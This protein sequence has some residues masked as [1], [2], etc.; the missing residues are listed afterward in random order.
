[1]SHIQYQRLNI[2]NEDESSED[3]DIDYPDEE[4][5]IPTCFLCGSSF[6][7]DIYQCERCYRSCCR[8]CINRECDECYMNVMSIHNNCLDCYAEVQERYIFINSCCQNIK[9]LEYQSIE[10]YNKLQ[11]YLPIDICNII[12]LY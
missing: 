3:V 11:Q 12:I 10:I 9:C 6:S 8:R 2:L 4:S 5:N 7:N 1:M